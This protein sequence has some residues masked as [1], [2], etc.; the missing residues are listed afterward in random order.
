M[1]GANICLHVYAHNVPID[2]MHPTRKINFQ[3]KRHFVLCRFILPAFF[4]TN[5]LKA[6]LSPCIRTISYLRKYNFLDQTLN[7]T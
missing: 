6:E 4:S 3:C 1:V 5:H 7:Q 2:A